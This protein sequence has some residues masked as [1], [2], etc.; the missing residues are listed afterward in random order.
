MKKI[1]LF[2]VFLVFQSSFGQEKNDCVFNNDYKQLTT[3]WLHKLGKTN[4]SWDAEKKQATLKLNDDLLF[5]SVGGCHHFTTSAIVQ[6]QNDTHQLEDTKYWIEKATLLSKKLHLNH[7][8]KM[9]KTANFKIV[10][11]RKNAIL[12][13]V[14]DDNTTDNLF[15]DGVEIRFEKGKKTIR[16]VKYYN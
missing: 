2:V 4:F 9:L 6:L 5:V 11:H 1:A 14:A 7:Y 13:D 8:H 3:D 10:K 16:F 12:L 15:Y